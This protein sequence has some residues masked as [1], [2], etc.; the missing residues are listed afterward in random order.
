[1]FSCKAVKV[2]HCCK[3]MII[4][5]SLLSQPCP[6]LNKGFY[7]QDVNYFRKSVLLLIFISLSKKGNLICAFIG[8]C[9][10]QEPPLVAA[11]EHLRCWE[12]AHPSA[13]IHWSNW[14]LIRSLLLLASVDLAPSV[15]AQSQLVPHRTRCPPSHRLPCCGH[16]QKH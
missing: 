1:M 4:L 3:F 6:L 10:N 9:R 7:C 8:T 11:S 14:T 13:E 12:A 16:K 15:C 5:L 2:H